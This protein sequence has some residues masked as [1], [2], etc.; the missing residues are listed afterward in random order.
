MQRYLCVFALRTAGKRHGEIVDDV[1][2]RVDRSQLTPLRG[3]L[4]FLKAVVV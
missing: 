2:A 4:L 3:A 1:D